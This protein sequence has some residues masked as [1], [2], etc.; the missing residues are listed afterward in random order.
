MF[1]SKSIDGA[2]IFVI[3]VKKY[4]DIG[5]TKFQGKLSENNPG[6]IHQTF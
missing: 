1:F 5:P 2:A 3:N 4:V 6:S